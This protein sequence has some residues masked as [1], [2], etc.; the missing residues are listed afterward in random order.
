MSISLITITRTI[1][2]TGILIT[3][4]TGRNT[5]MITTGNTTTTATMIIMI[6]TTTTTSMNLT[7][8]P[9]RNTSDRWHN[10]TVETLASTRKFKM[11]TIL[12][13]W[14]FQ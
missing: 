3:T 13:M 4:T 9:S 7:M 14:L 8:N 5:T 6:T 12:A 1:M 2:G 10:H 11:S